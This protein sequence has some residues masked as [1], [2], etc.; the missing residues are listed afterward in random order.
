MLNN[1]KNSSLTWS[2]G[3][4]IL[5]KVKYGPWKMM[6]GRVHS[7][8]YGIFSGAYRWEQSINSIL[9]SWEVYRWSASKDC[10][11]GLWIMN[12]TTFNISLI[13]GAL[14]CRICGCWK[15]TLISCQL[16]LSPFWTFGCDNNPLFSRILAIW[17]ITPPMKYH[18]F[19]IRIF[20]KTFPLSSMIR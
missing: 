6:V 12:P 19:G 14:I 13:K 20:Y 7:F 10:D 17:N 2:L 4:L 9:G 18:V 8:W 1:E 11:W 3:K 5:P 15:C 16:F